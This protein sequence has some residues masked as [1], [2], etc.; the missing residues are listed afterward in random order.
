[1][2]VIR[3]VSVTIGEP[4]LLHDGGFSLGNLLVWSPERT[5][6]YTWD[7][8]VGHAMPGSLRLDAP[9]D[10]RL[11]HWGLSPQA[12]RPVKLCGWVKTDRLE[13]CH[14]TLNLALFGPEKWLTT[15]CLAT[16][17]GAGEIE[18]GW[19]TVEKFGWLP[20][21]TTEWTSIEAFLPAA[22]IPSEANRAAFFV[23]VKGGGQ[24]RMWIDDLDLWQPEA[25]K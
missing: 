11:V 3:T 19:R 7:P 18:S 6:L 15:W 14:V 24:G 4:N 12:G 5:S 23:D 17:D 16:T 2:E 20:T 13:G 25:P 8:E 9:F 22:Q 10:R 1:V 21:K